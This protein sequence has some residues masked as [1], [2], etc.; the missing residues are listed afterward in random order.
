MTGR[1]ARMARLLYGGGL[2]RLECR[3]LRLQDVDFGQPRLVVRG[4]QGGKE[5]TPLLPRHLRDALQAPREAVTARH[6]RDRDAGGGDVDLPE[7]RARQSPQ[8]AWET[9]WQGGV[10]ARARALDPRAGRAMRPH[11]RASGL[12]K[13]GTR[14]AA[15]AGLD[16][17]VGGQT[18]RHRFATPRR[19]HGVHIRVLPALLGHA[20]VQTTAR[21]TQVMAR[22]IR[23]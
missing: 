16:Q 3:R 20:E 6:H 14:A 18:L 12:Q 9:G 4:G 13:A 19:E 7:A 23:P 21:D 11:V 15:Q 2:R 22:A 10:P 1:H 8:A 17:Q 5:R